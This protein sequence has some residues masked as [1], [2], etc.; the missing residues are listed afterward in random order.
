VRYKIPLGCHWPP[1][2]GRLE[3]RLAELVEHERRATPDARQE[4]RAR[5]GQLI[6]EIEKLKAATMAGELGR[7]E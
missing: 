4:L 6:V 5:Q 7:L 3:R 1:E 2:I